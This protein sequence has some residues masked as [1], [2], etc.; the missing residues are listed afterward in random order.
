MLLLGGGNG[1]PSCRPLVSLLT[2]EMGD[3]REGLG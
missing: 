2:P 1:D 3:E